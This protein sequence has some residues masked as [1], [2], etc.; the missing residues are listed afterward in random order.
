MRFFALCIA[1]WQ[2][3]HAGRQALLI[4]EAGRLVVNPLFD[5]VVF[6]AGAC[7]RCAVALTVQACNQA[8]LMPGGW[9]N[10]FAVQQRS[11]RY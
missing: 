2:C 9:F 4:S 3:M 1:L 8:L 6:C 7:W 10:R 11:D 5:L